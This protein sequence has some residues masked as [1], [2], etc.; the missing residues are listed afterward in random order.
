MSFKDTIRYFPE[1]IREDKEIPRDAKLSEKIA[2]D[3]HPAD[4]AEE[5]HDNKQENKQE[6]G[7]HVTVVDQ[8]AL[9]VAREIVKKSGI[10]PL[11]LNLASDFRPGGGW[12]KGS[13][14]QE[15]SL[16][17]RTTYALSLDN[18]VGYCNVKYPLQY[19]EAVFSPGIL[20][21]QDTN[22]K[23]LDWKDCFKFDGLALAAL[24]RPPLTSA[25][26]L[27][28][29]DREITRKKIQLLLAVAR[30]KKYTHLVLG[31]LGCGA[32]HNPP[33]DIAELFQEVIS[34][35]PKSSIQC[36]I[37]AV[38]ST[39]SNANFRIFSRILQP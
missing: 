8:D 17:Y 5:K 35:Q 33:Q 1:I 18:S 31:A 23:L 4:L 30:E 37:F 7:I 32:F 28:A 27:Q 34:E 10:R 16:F 13:M 15:E 20:V 25:K 6:N 39:A 2:Y 12:K 19:N 36:I 22:Y 21:F 24:R 26:H 14:A 38:L 29:R 9:E 11:V 3:P